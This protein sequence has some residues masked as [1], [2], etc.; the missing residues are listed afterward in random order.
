LDDI[1]I[2]SNTPEEHEDHV[3]KV[4]ARLREFGL[5][6]KAAKCEFGVK[7]IGFLGYVISQDGVGME[8]D[9][10]ATIEDWPTPGSLRDVQVF[11]GFTNFY[12]RFI[13]KYAKVSAPISDLL[14]K[15]HQG[16]EAS[17]WEWTREAELAF[18]KLKRL[19]G[20]APLLQHFDP[21]KPIVLQTDA[22][23][24]AIAGILNQYDGFGILRPV[25]FCSRKCT[26]A[27]QNYDTYDREL[28]AIVES[29][30]QW[31]HHL[32]GARYPVLVRCDHKNLEYFTTTKVLSRRQAR[33]AER[34][35]AFDFT[36]EHLE[37]KK[38]QPM[39]QAEGRIT[40]SAIIDQ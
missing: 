24:Y 12:R 27:E 4:L 10:V 22:S 28:L 9:R 39:D 7:K 30:K 37:G 20:E 19:F 38:I 14:R 18:R 15:D 11:L 17:K 16:K 31:R 25:N 35:S 2:Y 5:F 33:W 1:L 21:S 26:P 8:G 32:E 29:F 3:K 40:K 36:I 13:R 23:G 34:L 6:C